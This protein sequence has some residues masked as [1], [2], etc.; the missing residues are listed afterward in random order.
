MNAFQ[1]ELRRC[2]T[3]I[4]KCMEFIKFAKRL[5]LFASF[6]HIKS[7]IVIAFQGFAPA[8]LHLIYGQFASIYASFNLMRCC[9]IFA[10]FSTFF[11]FFCLLFFRHSL[12]SA[13]F[14]T[15]ERCA[16]DAPSHP[17]CRCCCCST[18]SS[19]SFSS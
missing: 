2:I 19:S 16:L 5:N 17:S 13:S 11:K 14:T 4:F 7:E 18:Q 9:W 12:F 15:S 8:Y 1:H 6:F 10:I 3:H